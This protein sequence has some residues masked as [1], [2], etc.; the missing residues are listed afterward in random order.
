[1]FC[2]SVWRARLLA[3]VLSFMTLVEPTQQIHRVFFAQKVGRGEDRW[4]KAEVIVIFTSGPDTISHC[5]PCKGALG[6]VVH[7]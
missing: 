1:M 5:F 6:F 4:Y 3:G 7:G 2:L